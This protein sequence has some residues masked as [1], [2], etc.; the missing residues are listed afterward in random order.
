MH[1]CMLKMMSSTHKFKRCV[2]MPTYCFVPSGRSGTLLHLSPKRHGFRNTFILIAILI[3]ISYGAGR[4]S[5]TIDIAN[6]IFRVWNLESQ[7]IRIK[8]FFTHKEAI[9]PILRHEIGRCFEAFSSVF[10]IASYIDVFVSNFNFRCEA[11]FL[12][13]NNNSAQTMFVIK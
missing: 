3:L 1:T 8:V 10:V 4:S 12:S 7:S 2:T 6:A 11:R 5:G 13:D 9:F